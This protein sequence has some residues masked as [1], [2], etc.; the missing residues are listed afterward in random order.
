MSE[1]FAPLVRNTSI[2][3]GLPSFDDGER[4]GS[5]IASEDNQMRDWLMRLGRMRS[6]HFLGAL[7]DAA[8]KADDEDY[9][10]IRPA[11]MDLKRK[12]PDARVEVANTRGAA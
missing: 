6:G 12:Y 11:L 3:R 8:M 4:K 9:S 10:I 1:F 2:D 5:M 7:A